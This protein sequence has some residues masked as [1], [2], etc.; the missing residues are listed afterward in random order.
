MN[1]LNPLTISQS[2]GKR[3]TYLLTEDRKKYLLLS[4]IEEHTLL[5]HNLL[6]LILNHFKV[7]QQKTA[8]FTFK[9][10][11]YLCLEEFESSFDF[12]IWYHYLWENKR[13]FNQFLNP[14]EY[15]KIQL[16]NLLFP[17]FNNPISI[18]I[19]HDRKFTVFACLNG[20]IKPE[21]IDFYQKTDSDLGLRE[22][23][24]KKFLAHQKDSLVEIKEAFQILFHDKFISDLKYQISLNSNLR[25]HYWSELKQCIDSKHRSFVFSKIDDLLIRL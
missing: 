7:S 21:G 19:S 10:N 16:I 17:V 14:S 11:K 8:S 13:K 20:V 18:R 22:P 24:I 23:E 3:P 9:G 15:F 12:D 4:P 2:I 5:Q 25:N 1:A 6:K